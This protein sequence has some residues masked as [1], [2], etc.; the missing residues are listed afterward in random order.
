M[1]E[2]FKYFMFED[3]GFIRQ[4]PFITIVM[5]VIGFVLLALGFTGPADC[6]IDWS[7]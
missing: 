5:A 2:N 6:K 1:W 4:L 3:C 7:C